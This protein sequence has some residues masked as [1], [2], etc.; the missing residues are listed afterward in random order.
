[1]ALRPGVGY[2]VGVDRFRPRA[3]SPKWLSLP[4]NPRRVL[5][6]DVSAGTVALPSLTTGLVPAGRHGNSATRPKLGLERK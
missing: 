6:L 4:P 2:E 1:M 5:G 3:R